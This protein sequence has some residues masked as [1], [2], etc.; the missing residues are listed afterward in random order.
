V[1]VGAKRALAWPVMALG[2]RMP[3][4]PLVA[5]RGIGQL[6]PAYGKRDRQGLAEGA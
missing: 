6:P 4:V 1:K 5:T 3:I 2:P